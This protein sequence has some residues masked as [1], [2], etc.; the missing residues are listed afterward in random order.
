MT[1]LLVWHELSIKWS[2]ISKS[3]FT[4]K[5]AYL[6]KVGFIYTHSV[7]PLVYWFNSRIGVLFHLIQKISTTFQHHSKIC[8]LWFLHQKECSFYTHLFC[9]TEMRLMFISSTAI[10]VT[11]SDTCPNPIR[12]YSSCTNL[13]HMSFLIPK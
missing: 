4:M 5:T 12:Y 6:L 8:L 3:N 10:W 11:G 7:F 1:C 9:C 13:S 2:N